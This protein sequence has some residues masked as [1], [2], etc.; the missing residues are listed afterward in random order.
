MSYQANR[1]KKTLTKTIQF[2][3]TAVVRTKVT[4]YLRSTFEQ[5]CHDQRMWKT[6]FSTVPDTTKNI[7]RLQQY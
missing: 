4:F 6:H 2:V 7:H 1:E 3:A 5:K